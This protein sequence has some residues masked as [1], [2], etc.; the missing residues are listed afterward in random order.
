MFSHATDKKIVVDNPIVD[1]DG[2]E[3]TR[4]IWSMIK[5]KVR[6]RGESED[7]L[8]TSRHITAHYMHLL[9]RLGKQFISFHP[10]SGVDS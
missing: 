2:D 3:M 6:L 8:L 4:I 5:E 10:L 7:E 1:L 9:V